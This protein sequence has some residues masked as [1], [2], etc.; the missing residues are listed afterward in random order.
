MLTALR[1]VSVFF[2]FFF[3]FT[4]NHTGIT[5]VSRFY[6]KPHRYYKG[7]KKVL[8]LEPFTLKNIPITQLWNE[9]LVT[10]TFLSPTT[11][12]VLHGEYDFQPHRYYKS[13]PRLLEFEQMIQ[14]LYS[15]ICGAS[16]GHVCARISGG[17]QSSVCRSGTFPAGSF[18]QFRRRR[19]SAKRPSHN[20]VAKMS[21]KISFE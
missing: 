20:L 13:Q 14:T 11:T 15:L 21:W 18:L 16:A 5:R 7:K 9:R 12:Q 1:C 8:L 4:Q 2:F 10:L 19:Q 3:V 17:I 6:P